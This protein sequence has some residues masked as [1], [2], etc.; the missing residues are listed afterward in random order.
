MGI[1]TTKVFDW[2]EDMIGGS[3]FSGHFI[4]QMF[5]VMFLN[6]LSGDA[7]KGRTVSP[8]ARIVNVSGGDHRRRRRRRLIDRFVTEIDESVHELVEILGEKPIHVV[9]FLLEKRTLVGDGAGKLS[10]GGGKEFVSQ[11]VAVGEHLRRSHHAQDPDYR[12]PLVNGGKLDAVPSVRLQSEGFGVAAG[13]HHR[14]V[15]VDRSQII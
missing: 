1:G 13:L 15:A 11:R 5:V 8:E 6:F 4:P 3:Q 9:P 12:H 7:T 2:N 10:H 14:R